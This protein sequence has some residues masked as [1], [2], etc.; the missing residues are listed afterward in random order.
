MK[1]SV[2]RKKYFVNLTKLQYLGKWFE[3][4]R[5][6]NSFQEKGDCVTAQYS[7]NPD[8][9]TIKVTN[10][11][12]MLPN[13]TNIISL[14]GTGRL[15]SAVPPIDG[16]LV[17]NFNGHDSDYWVLNTDYTNYAVV[18]SCVNVGNNSMRKC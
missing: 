3:I 13:K 12:K 7:F 4:K 15:E 1:I 11:M 18:W 8:N 5:Y 10:E 17:V 14:N 2:F 6:V 9:A 16:R